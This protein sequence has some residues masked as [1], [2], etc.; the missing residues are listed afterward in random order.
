VRKRQ[1]VAA[2]GRSLLEP[3]KQQTA[4]RLLRLRRHLLGQ[5][6][7]LG[8]VLLGQRRVLLDGRGGLLG[9]G[10]GGRDRQREHDDG[11]GDSGEQPRPV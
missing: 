3:I 6:L 8:H 7:R 2:R 11:D 1:S 4:H 5:L 9:G 10:G